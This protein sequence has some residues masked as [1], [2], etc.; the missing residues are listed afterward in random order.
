MKHKFHFRS[1]VEAFDAA[2]NA[3]KAVLL[4]NGYT[5]RERSFVK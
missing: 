2:V 1:N 3:I 5:E 4:A